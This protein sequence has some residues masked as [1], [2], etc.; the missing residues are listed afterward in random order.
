MGGGAAGKTRLPDW[1]ANLRADDSAAVWV[2]RARIPVMAQELKGG[3][4]DRAQQE[5]AA[6]WPGV[7]RY[8]R[9]S[10]R[11]IPYFR[12]VPTQ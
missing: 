2:R 4:R 1:V 5:A 6:I 9:L 10:G 3:D 11:V 12:L 7:A 8:E